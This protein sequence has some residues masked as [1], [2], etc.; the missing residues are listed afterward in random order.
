MPSL[1]TCLGLACVFV[2]TGCAAREVPPKT[3]PVRNVEVPPLAARQAPPVEPQE[4]ASGASAPTPEKPQ[5]DCRALLSAGVRIHDE[6]RY[7]E[8]IASYRRGLEQCGPGHRFLGEIGYSLLAKGEFD[9]AAAAFLKEIQAPAPAPTAFGNLTSVLPKLSPQMLQ[10][11][12]L[13]G[14]L[15]KAP[16]Y[17][18]DI[19]GEYLWVRNIACG[20]G[21]G[22]VKSQA[23]INDQGRQLDMLRFQCPDG[24]SHEAYFDFSADPAEQAMRR[25]LQGT[26]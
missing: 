11:V 7:D 17:V 25:E 14:T 16:I 15:K 24:S 4:G 22:Q 26:P 19:D 8:A 6:G 1:Y 10:V 20:V 13:T 21:E 23:L 2:L 18:P 12:M 5:V 9:A 3:S